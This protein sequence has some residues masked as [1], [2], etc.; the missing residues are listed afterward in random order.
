[1]NKWAS[2]ND[3]VSN[4][5]L[6]EAYTSRVVDHNDVCRSTGIMRANGRHTDTLQL[7]RMLGIRSNVGG[8]HSQRRTIYVSTIDIEV[9]KKI[10]KAIGVDYE[11]VYQRVMCP[12]GEDEA[13][14]D[15]RCLFCIEELSVAA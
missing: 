3:R 7:L 4:A 5:P 12:C 2:R 15:G 6:R 10:C 14:Q 8:P 1:M 9:A 11:E 13:V